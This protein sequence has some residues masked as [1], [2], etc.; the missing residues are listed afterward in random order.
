MASATSSA[1]SSARS[2]AAALILVTV[3]KEAVAAGIT[4]PAAGVSDLGAVVLEATFTAIFLVVILMSSKRS[5]GLAALAIPLT[6][7]GIHFAIATVT[8]S[9]VNPARSIGSAVVGGDLGQLW[10]YIVGPTI[11]GVIG[12]GCVPVRGSRTRPRPS[13]QRR[14]TSGEEPVA[15]VV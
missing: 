7:V 6:L 4:K 14:P 3:S 1:R 10:I 9:S 11:G 13:D 12:W 2:L 8:G 15:S 5:P